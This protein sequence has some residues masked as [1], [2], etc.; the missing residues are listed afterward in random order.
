MITNDA[1]GYT[2]ETDKNGNVIYERHPD[3]YE[4]YNTYNENNKLIRSEQRYSNGRI[5]VENFR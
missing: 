1:N 5:E 3:G 2:I 4:E